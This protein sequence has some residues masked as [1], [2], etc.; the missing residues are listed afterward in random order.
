M[1]SN[2]GTEWNEEEINLSDFTER[3]GD[4]R[5]GGETCGGEVGLKSAGNPENSENVFITLQVC[6]TASGGLYLPFLSESFY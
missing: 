6:F 4:V 3:R 5:A 2:A 1:S